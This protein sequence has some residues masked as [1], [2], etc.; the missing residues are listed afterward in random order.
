MILS[1]G[2]ENGVAPGGLGWDSVKNA[3]G[4]FIDTA[5]H[6]H[7]ASSL[8][9]EGNTTV[10]TAVSKTLPNS[11]VLVG[12]TYFRVDSFSSVNQI[13][14]GAGA[15]Q[16][17]IV[18][19]HTDGTLRGR[20]GS[21]LGTRTTAAITAN[22]LYLLDWIWDT[23]GTTYTVDFRLS[24]A[25]GVLIEVGAQTVLA[26]QT[27]QAMTKLLAGDNGLTTIKT[28]FDDTRVTDTGYPLG[29]GT[30][31]DAHTPLITTFPASWIDNPSLISGGI[32][33]GFHAH[34]EEIPS[35][36]ENPQ[37]Y[38]DSE[39]TAGRR[40]YLTHTFNVDTLAP[41]NMAIERDLIDG[42]ILGHQC[43]PIY[44]PFGY[45]NTPNWPAAGLAAFSNGS[46]DSVLQAQADV[47]NRDM[48]DTPFLVRMLR[49]M[50]SNGTTY[51]P[52]GAANGGVNET[53]GLTGTYVTAWKYIV[54]FWRAR[55]PN[56]RFIWC[57]AFGDVSKDLTEHYLQW[58]PPD[59][60]I[61]WLGCD[62]YVKLNGDGL[63]HSILDAFA[64]WYAWAKDQTKP[65]MICETQVAV[66][67]PTRIADIQAY[68]AAFNAMPKIKVVTF[69]DSRTIGAYQIN[70]TP[71]GYVFAFQGVVKTAPF[72]GVAGGNPA[73]PHIVYLP[74]TLLASD[75]DGISLVEISVNGAAYVPMT[76]TGSLDEYV[77]NQAPL[78]S[79]FAP[80]TDNSI[81]V[82]AT[83][84][85][86]TDPKQTV[87]T[88]TI[89]VILSN[90]G[91]AGPPAVAIQT[92]T[93][94]DVSAT[95]TIPIAVQVSDPDGITSVEFTL[96][97]TTGWHQ[98]T[99]SG[100]GLYEGIIDV[101]AFPPPGGLTAFFTATVR[102]T[103]NHPTDPLTSPPAT[104]AFGYSPP[105]TNS[106][107]PLVSVVSPARFTDKTQVDLVVDA[108]DPDG[109]ATVEVE[110]DG[111]GVWVTVPLQ[112]G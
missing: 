41:P 26:G 53:P 78:Y 44:N 77:L 1:T 47:W 87:S 21:T 4:L 17:C 106:G 80:G 9:V 50:S 72:T 22:T 76:P 69:W 111:S 84:A 3:A 71:P 66:A 97:V 28:W 57:P 88:E 96:D 36:P 89:T 8:R 43:W 29:P 40:S 112:G 67:D 73:T 23:S 56:A 85:H 63:Y 83:D 109:V 46:M 16:A 60:H 93:D 64:T 18:Q 82:R 79:S 33:T 94:G 55:C 11:M 54:A 74:I 110:I 52:S 39:T 65:L 27:A 7:G 34:G 2:Y 103:D 101:R 6:Q 31:N 32:L 108:D 25:A 90:T 104:V 91:N 51:G 62:G 99:D 61:D 35:D 86:P 100:G 70:E 68:T 20:I 37:S 15:L 45:G 75:P 107:A 59:T 102:A 58:K 13:L 38:R 24:T 92:P 98:L 42:T 19:V 12:S 95:G 81:S 48:P 10:T 30:G 5:V 14:R 49:E 105:L